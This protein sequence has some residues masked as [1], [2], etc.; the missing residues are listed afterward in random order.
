MTIR[1]L[2]FLRRLGPAAA[3][4]AMTL[5]VRLMPPMPSIKPL[6]AWDYHL[7]SALLLGKHFL[8]SSEA[9]AAVSSWHT[10]P[11]LIVLHG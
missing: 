6:T 2:C 7:R 11:R 9:C 1:G 5:A 3:F 10:A 4:T 8:G